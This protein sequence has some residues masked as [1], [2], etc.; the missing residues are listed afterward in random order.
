MQHVRSL[1]PRLPRRTR[2]LPPACGRAPESES[3]ES[4]ILLFDAL[5][6]DAAERCETLRRDHARLVDDHA[7]GEPGSWQELL[8]REQQDRSLERLRN[9]EASYRQLHGLLVAAVQQAVGT[10]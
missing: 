10:A 3:L 6:A 1:A 5:V 8:Q 2:R 4:R 9:A 7:S